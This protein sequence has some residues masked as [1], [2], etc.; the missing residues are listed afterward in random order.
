MQNQEQLEET[1]REQTDFPVQMQQPE[2]AAV[3]ENPQAESQKP[4]KTLA[5]RIL[6]WT[7]QKWFFPSILGFAAVVVVLAVLSQFVCAAGGMYYIHAESLDLRDKV[8]TEE[9][10][11]DL[12]AKMPDC[13]IRWNVPFQGNYIA[14]DTEEITVTSLTEEDVQLLNYVTG[15]KKVDGT[16]CDDYLLLALLQEHRPEVDVRY[17]VPVSG[18]AYAK[19]TEELKLDSFTEQDAKVLPALL[20]LRKVEISNCEDYALLQQLQEDHPEWNLAYNVRV[21]DQTVAWDTPEIETAALSSQDLD[22]VLS[23]LPKLRVLHVVNPA[24]DHRELFALRQEYPDVKLHWTVEMFGQTFTEETKE[25]DISGNIVERCEDVEKLVACLPNLEKL[26]M[27]DCGIENEV[28]AEFRERQRE[29]YKVVWT[30]YMG[31]ICSLRT[32]AIYFHPYQQG[33]GYFYDDETEN[34]K[35]CEDIICLDLGHHDITNID[36]LRYM[37]HLKYLI[38]AHTRIRDVSAI[39]N[40]QELIYLEV[41]WSRIQDLSPLVEL[42]ALEDLNLSRTYCDLTPILEMTWLKNLWV[43][44]R[45]EEDQQRLI[46]A[47]PDTH[48]ELNAVNTK[49]WRHLPNYYAQRDILGMEYMNQ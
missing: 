20:R 49:G 15:L 2:E 38:L 26:I 3:K 35:Y 32:D 40:C 30:V 25:V 27:S 42:K 14:N 11:Q 4:E 12:S 43:P 28:M 37:P 6:V 29:N 33:E 48:L 31:N 17:S 21:G 18:T 9:D 19:N 34:L 41:D 36:F 1:V 47:L 7:K 16:G 5:S 24:A 46:E 8:L 45:S 22:L 10:F 44:N 39:V 13:R 23:G